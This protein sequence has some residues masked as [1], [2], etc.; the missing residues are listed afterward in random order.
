MCRKMLATSIGTGAFWLP[1]QV[2]SSQELLV[3][4]LDLARLTILLGPRPQFWMKLV[5]VSGSTSNF[6]DGPKFFPKKLS[7]STPRRPELYH[8]R[9]SASHLVLS[10]SHM[11]LSGT[12]LLQNPINGSCLTIANILAMLVIL[13]IYTIY[14]YSMLYLHDIPHENVENFTHQ[15]HPNLSSFESCAQVLQPSCWSPC[16]TFKNGLRDVWQPSRLGI[17]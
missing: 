1:R 8:T 15:T 4:W 16:R 10:L 6:R 12:W 17:P 3:D 14:I 9:E 5:F 13:Y 11:G 7:R 2:D